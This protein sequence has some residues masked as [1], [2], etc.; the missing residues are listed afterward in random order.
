MENQFGCS[1][2]INKNVQRSLCPCKI[3]ISLVVYKLILPISL[4]EGQ[5]AGIY[6]STVVIRDLNDFSALK[7]LVLT[8]AG[9]LPLNL[10]VLD[11]IEITAIWL[12][13]S[14]VQTILNMAA[15]L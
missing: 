6:S 11:F 2:K 5:V 3:Q 1:N 4:P 14:F 7:Y 10:P 9:M 8:L 13:L 12:F 15:T